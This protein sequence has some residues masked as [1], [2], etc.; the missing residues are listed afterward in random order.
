[1]LQLFFD[2]QSFYFILLSNYLDVNNL[3]NIL[4]EKS[5]YFDICKA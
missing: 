3:D 4:K 1:M 2:F 5:R